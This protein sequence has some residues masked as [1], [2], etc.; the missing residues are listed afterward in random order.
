[1]LVSEGGTLWTDVDVIEDTGGVGVGVRGGGGTS[2][3]PIHNPPS[4]PLVSSPPPPPL[5]DPSLSAVSWKAGRGGG[6]RTSSLGGGRVDV[7]ATS[8]SP[9]DIVVPG[10]EDDDVFMMMMRV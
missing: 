1:M 6:G 7:E 10:C 8:R 3:T 2:E 9:V 4:L 5:L